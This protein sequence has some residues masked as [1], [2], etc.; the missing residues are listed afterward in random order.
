MTA[1]SEGDPMTGYTITVGPVTYAE[2]RDGNPITFLE[3][4]AW[5]E[6]VGGTVIR[7][8]WGKIVG[9]GSMSDRWERVQL[10]RKRNR[11]VNVT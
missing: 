1:Y 2:R 11:R 5:S 10:A 3:A 6:G 9:T 4:W 7:D 8:P